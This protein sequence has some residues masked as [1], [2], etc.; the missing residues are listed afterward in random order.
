MSNQTRNTRFRQVSVRTLVALVSATLLG[1]AGAAAI[2]WY[3]GKPAASMPSGGASAAITPQQIATQAPR[4]KTQKAATQTLADVMQLPS[5]FARAA[6]LHALVVDA[7]TPQLLAL[8]E[9]AK[10]DDQVLERQANLRILLQRY[11]ELEPEAALNT[12]RRLDNRG[13]QF[14]TTSLYMAWLRVDAQ[15]ATAYL[16]QRPPQERMMV[17]ASLQAIGHSSLDLSLASAAVPGKFRG[18]LSELARSNPLQAWTEAA[19]L[20]DLRK[21]QQEQRGIIQTWVRMDPRS[22]LEAIANLPKHRRVQLE[23]F[24]VNLWANSDSEAAL[25][26]LQQRPADSRQ[27]HLLQ[28]VVAQVARHDLDR[29]LSV[30][31]E[32]PD[33]QRSATID[34]T[35]LQISQRDPELALEQLQ[36]SGIDLSTSKT[37]ANILASGRIYTHLEALGLAEELGEAA[38]GNLARPLFSRWAASDPAAAATQLERIPEPSLR[39][40]VQRQVLHQWALKDP[41]AAADWIDSRPQDQRDRLRVQL[42]GALGNVDPVLARSHVDKIRDGEQYDRAAVRLLAQLRH[43]PDEV[44]RVLESLRTDSG[45]RN[46]EQIMQQ[47]QDHSG[48]R[49]FYPGIYPGTIERTSPTSGA[50]LLQNGP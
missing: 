20:K 34:S 15:A 5:P 11:L 16:Q 13:Q 24:A 22:A 27:S 48:S 28:M 7:D 47:L 38:L 32:L 1:L 36:R 35:L 41:E 17:G 26:W 21:Q 29:A 8:I 18:A 40:R 2:W 6:A 43:D 10:R 46:A 37:Y 19:Q 25:A 42:V 49:S 44:E 45:K 9:A 12:A 3:N 30:A 33:K 14:F 39:Q 50:V 23:T 31:N 4:S